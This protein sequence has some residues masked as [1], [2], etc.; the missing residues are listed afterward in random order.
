MINRLF[1]LFVALAMTT[2]LYARDDRIKLPIADAIGTEEAKSKLNQGIKFVFGQGASGVSKK[3]GN[4][5][6]NKKTNAFG[7]SDQAACNRAFLSAML[8]FQD[9]AV[10]EGGNAVINIKSYYKRN[11]FV[12]TTEFECGAGNIMAGVTFTGDVVKLK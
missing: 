2:S 3:F 5:Q 10:R 8:S 11:T 4:F 9:R 7:K 6:S 1:I 12:S